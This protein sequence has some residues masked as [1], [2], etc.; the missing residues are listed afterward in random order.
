M[1]P[2][3]AGGPSEPV[4]EIYRVP[5]LDYV[6]FAKLMYKTVSKYYTRLRDD[7][8]DDYKIPVSFFND[9]K[10]NASVHPLDIF[11]VTFLAVIWTLLR[12]DLTERIILVSPSSL[13]GIE[14][15]GEKI[16]LLPLSSAIKIFLGTVPTAG[17]GWKILT[18][19]T[20]LTQKIQ[21]KK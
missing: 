5:T 15:Q 3:Q 9:I 18:K 1:E 14:S 16:Y 7:Y 12:A 2:T 8:W 21:I 13:K 6:T 4:E 19:T 11:L 20:F 10:N 17:V